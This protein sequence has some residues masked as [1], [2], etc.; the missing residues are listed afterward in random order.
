MRTYACGGRLSP[1]WILP[2]SPPHPEAT[3]ILHNMSRRMLQSVKEQLNDCLVFYFMS[4][5]AT[6][7]SILVWVL[8]EWGP[9]LNHLCDDVK[10][11]HK[12]FL[13]M[14]TLICVMKGMEFPTWPF[15]LPVSTTLTPKIH[16]GNGLFCH[17]VGW[18]KIEFTSNNCHLLSA[19]SDLATVFYDVI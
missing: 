18:G 11:T 1:A 6:K 3:A 5:P 9:F 19:A 12:T 2:G 16:K 13:Y 4:S 7:G 17:M 15:L 8:T 14:I 10:L